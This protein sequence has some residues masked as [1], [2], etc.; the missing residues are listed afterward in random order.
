MDLSIVMSATPQDSDRS[1]SQR[2]S[3]VA[4][5]A[6]SSAPLTTVLVAN[7]QLRW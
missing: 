1:R 4:N 2:L 6:M 3:E 7:S 5:R